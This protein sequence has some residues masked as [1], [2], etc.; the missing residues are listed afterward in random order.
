MLMGGLAVPSLAQDYTNIVLIN[1]DDVGFGDFP[2]MVHTAI[3]L[4]I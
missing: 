4:P 2:A 1:L 3:R